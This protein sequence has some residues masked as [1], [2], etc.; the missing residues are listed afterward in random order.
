MSDLP[1]SFNALKTSTHKEQQALWNKYFFKEH[2]SKKPILK[3][4]WYRIQCVQNNSYIE[5]RHQTKLNKYSKSPEYHIKKAIKYKIN[6]KAGTQITKTYKGKDHIVTVNGDNSF[7]Y[8]DK[9]YKTI[10]AVAIA[11][12]GSKVSGNHFFGLY[13]KK[14]GEVVD[15]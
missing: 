6:F 11:I 10:S 12:C 14:T 15:A 3:T 2:Y 8:D 7:L 5:N 9:E 1:T 13:N 4:L